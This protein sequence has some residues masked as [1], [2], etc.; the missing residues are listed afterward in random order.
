MRILQAEIRAQVR[1]KSPSF[2]K[3]SLKALTQTI[4]DLT[5]AFFA[6]MPAANEL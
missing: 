3:L 1:S 6:D 5:Q 2:W 4:F